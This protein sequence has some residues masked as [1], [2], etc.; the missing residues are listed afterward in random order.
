MIGELFSAAHAIVGRL[1]PVF[2]ETF[3]DQSSV[4]SD[5][6]D[7]DQVGTLDLLADEIFGE[8]L[9]KFYPGVPITSEEGARNWPPS[10][11]D[12]WLVDPFDGTDNFLAGFMI[13]GAMGTLIVHREVVAVFVLMPFEYMLAC[14]GM[15]LAARGEGSFAAGAGGSMRPMRVTK[16]SRLAEAFV[17]I[18]GSSRKLAGIPAVS[19]LAGSARRARAVFGAGASAK[20]VADGAAN[21]RGV[22]LLA[23]FDNKPWDNLPAPLLVEEAG[24]KATDHEGNP[25]TITNY[26]DMLVS[27][28]FIHDEALRVLGAREEGAR[29]QS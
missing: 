24:G 18:E 25:I 4:V 23:A 15:Y 21:P 22:S 19:R 26:K 12:T 13:A 1:A 16:T 10:I 7:G 8:V 28:G 6:P 11:D 3:R 20:V 27:N 2:A 29:C 9:T 17:A 5:K 14:G